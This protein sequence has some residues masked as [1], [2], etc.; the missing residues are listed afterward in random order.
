MSRKNSLT[1]TLADDVI[2]GVNGKNG[3]AAELGIKPAQ[4]YYLIARGVIPV[5]RL[6]HRTLV[7]SRKQL[8]RLV[9]NEIPP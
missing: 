6:G 2:W 7:A 5:R 8:Q 1:G 3:I 9:E 4:A